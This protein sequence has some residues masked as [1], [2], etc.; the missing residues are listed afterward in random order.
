[1]PVPPCPPAL[2]LFVSI[3]PTIHSIS[4]VWSWSGLNTLVTCLWWVS[5]TSFSSQ[6]HYSWARIN[7]CSKPWVSSSLEQERAI[8]IQWWHWLFHSA[9][10]I[11]NPVTGLKQLCYHSAV[12]GLWVDRTQGSFDSTCFDMA[13]CKI[14]CDSLFLNFIFSF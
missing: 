11:V 12:T 7:S 8:I 6:S 9:S 4:W 5:W 10:E 13:T 2:W 1:M 3:S 14:F